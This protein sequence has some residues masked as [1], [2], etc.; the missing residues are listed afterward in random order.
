MIRYLKQSLEE[1]E[2]RNQ[3]AAAIRM[4]P[5]DGIDLVRLRLAPRMAHR[6]TLLVVDWMEVAGVPIWDSKIK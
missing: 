2:R 6:R 4:S 5:T 1:D 3:T